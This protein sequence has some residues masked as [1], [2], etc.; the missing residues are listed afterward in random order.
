MVSIIPLI[1]RLIPEKY[2]VFGHSH[3]LKLL[4]NLYHSDIFSALDA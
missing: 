1:D 4:A 2:P 3:C